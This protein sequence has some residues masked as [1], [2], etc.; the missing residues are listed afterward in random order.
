MILTMTED[1]GDNFILMGMG[2]DIAYRFSRE[3]LFNV[4]KYNR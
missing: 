2:L 4:M 3:L 1:R